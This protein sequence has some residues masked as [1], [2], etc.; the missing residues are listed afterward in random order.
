MT[1]TMTKSKREQPWHVQVAL[2]DVPEAGL[3]LELAADAD[4]RAAIARLAGLRDIPRLE[5][6]FDLQRYG[7][8]GLHVGG[9]VRATIGQTCVVTLEPMESD[10]VETVD[11]VFVPGDGTERHARSEQDDGSEEPETL[12][13][14][15]VDLGAI[16]AE[17]LILGLDPYPRRP[18]ATFQAPATNEPSGS[19]FA[20]LAALKTESGKDGG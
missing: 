9:P 6:S 18:G 8:G 20:A 5:A 14:G 4:T 3:H 15:T 12:V 2:S 11:L 17:F 16:A 19:A 10:V 7:G 1:T 13:N